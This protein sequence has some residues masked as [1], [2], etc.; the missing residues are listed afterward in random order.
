MR[1]L[2]ASLALAS[3]V[4]LLLR[5]CSA[6]YVSGVARLNSGATEAFLTKFSFSPS[7]AN[8]AVSR[9]RGRFHTENAQY[10]KNGQRAH[11]L[12]LVLIPENKWAEY[13]RMKRK[14]SLCKDRT[15]GLNVWRKGIV[16][17]STRDVHDAPKRKGEEFEVISNVAHMHGKSR[18]F[19]VLLADCMLEEY[20]A[21]R[22]PPVFYELVL[23]DRDS[24]LPRSEQGLGAFHL[25]LLCVL[26]LCLALGAAALREQ[27]RRSGSV[28]LSCLWLLLALALEANSQFFE[29]WHIARYAADGKG[30]RLRHGAIPGDFLAELSNVLA[31]NL[32]SLLLLA[33]AGGWTLLAPLETSAS[34][35]DRLEGGTGP[36][37]ADDIL[38]EK[39]REKMA[40]RRGGALSEWLGLRG[41]R[42]LS[43]GPKQREALRRLDGAFES[44]EGALASGPMGSERSPR[45]MM[46][47]GAVLVSL[48]SLME[49]LGR[50]Y[51]D[52]FNS[53][54]DHDHWPG[55]LQMALRVF[56]AAA[57]LAA[58]SRTMNDPRLNPRAIKLLRRLR[59]V[60]TAFFL[61]FPMIVM[62]SDAALSVFDQHYA[63]VAGCELV[64]SAAIV[65]LF[66]GLLDPVGALQPAYNEHVAPEIQKRFGVDATLAGDLSGK[67][68]L[69]F[70]D[71][72]SVGRFHRR[73]ADDSTVRR[74][75]PKGKVAVD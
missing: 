71:A 26:L 62:L 20:D 58:S 15:A 51:E 13:L 40:P 30:L 9:V 3:G 59:V 43:L 49:L 7:D 73:G 54:H 10:F 32:V 68:T 42:R 36:S 41:S 45:V 50:S 19:Y 53:F 56:L 72:S 47:A 18:Y 22:T 33:L 11:R 44:L 64:Q 46:A 14:G 55:V 34:R 74:R 57:F 31:E 4:L 16:P 5:P 66:F 75:A 23:T 27:L 35:L 2:V 69:G 48:Q 37:G 65:A 61:S 63:V 17:Q 67:A 60:G 39:A 29:L 8:R 12:E 28:H 38:N 52:D 24:H 70:T 21:S 25:L 1:A 6:K